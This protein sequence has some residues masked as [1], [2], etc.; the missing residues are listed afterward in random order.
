[1]CFST[2]IRPKK[3]KRVRVLT[4]RLQQTPRRPETQQKTEVVSKSAD[5]SPLFFFFFA[6]SSNSSPSPPPFHLPPPLR[7]RPPLS[8]FSSHISPP[9]TLFVAPQSRGLCRRFPR[10]ICGI[11][12]GSLSPSQRRGCH[13]PHGGP[14]GGGRGGAKEASKKGGG[15]C[16]A[17]GRKGG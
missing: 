8:P 14:G 5:T 4:Q 3:M 15:V 10:S 17:G 16:S 6:P 11:R 13:L 1:M 7:P 2:K 9:A 12:H